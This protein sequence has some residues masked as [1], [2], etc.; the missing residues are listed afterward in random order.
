LRGIPPPCR[1]A[2]AGDGCRDSILEQLD[3]D[4]PELRAE[5]ASSQLLG[6][7]PARHVLAFEPLASADA[8]SVVDWVAPSVQRY[9]T[10]DLGA[11]T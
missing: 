2:R 3:V 11:V 9:L 7:G 8:A 4:R 5:L 1:A 10:G 6:L